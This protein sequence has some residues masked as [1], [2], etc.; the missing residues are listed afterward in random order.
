MVTLQI[1]LCV[2]FLIMN[3]DMWLW[4]IALFI[5]IIIL[6]YITYKRK[7]QCL[8]NLYKDEFEHNNSLISDCPKKG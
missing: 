8:R 5:L 2:S 7:D 6:A 3:F 4:V 1:L